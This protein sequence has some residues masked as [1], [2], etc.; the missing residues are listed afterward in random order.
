MLKKMIFLSLMF[1]SWQSNLFS[2]N[3][4]NHP[5][6]IGEN[7]RCKANNC[8]GVLT[9]RLAED[10]NFSDCKKCGQRHFFS[11]QPDT[12]QTINAITPQTSSVMSNLRKYGI[13]VAIIAGLGLTWK[14][15]TQIR[16]LFGK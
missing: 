3:R 15:R 14:Y 8:D 13:P 1:I 11:L 12:N 4:Q 10:Q 9:K 2:M 5:I 16:N 7:D 6:A